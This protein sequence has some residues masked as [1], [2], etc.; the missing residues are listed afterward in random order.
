MTNLQNFHVVE[1]RR[2]GKSTRRLFTWFGNFSVLCMSF[3]W[4]ME[5]KTTQMDYRLSA[6]RR[7]D[8]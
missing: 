3:S 4:T 8:L 5:T 2:M 6:F 1:L 7:I